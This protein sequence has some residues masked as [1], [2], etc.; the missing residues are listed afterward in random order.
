[1]INYLFNKFF[2]SIHNELENDFFIKNKK[3]ILLGDGFFARGFLH[4]IDH[5]KFFITQIYKD[6]FINPQ[7]LMYSLQRN[8]YYNG[9]LH[10]RDFFTEPPNVI[11]KQNIKELNIDIKNKVKINN[12]YY[13]YNYLIIGL[14]AHKSLHDW[15]NEINR[16]N[17]INNYSNNISII[18]MGPT[19]LELSLILSKKH[20]IYL[21]DMLP[22]DIIFKN[23]ENILKILENKNINIRFGIKYDSSYSKEFIFCGGSKPNQ[24]TNNYK[25]NKYLQINDNKFLR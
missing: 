16:L 13:N 11:I 8:Q 24:L 9:T 12:H 25:I 23:K 1:M 6:E 17:Y 5:S 15:K 4:Y 19:G 10:L 20:N 3:I 14:G 2:Y 22:K 21:F 7:D 18:G